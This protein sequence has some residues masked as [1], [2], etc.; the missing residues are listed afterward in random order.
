MLKLSYEGCNVFAYLKGGQ[1][2]HYHFDSIDDFLNSK[3]KG[4]VWGTIIGGRDTTVEE[5]L[6]SRPNFPL[7]QNEKDYIAWAVSQP[8]LTPQVR[9]DLK[10]YHKFRIVSVATAINLEIKTFYSP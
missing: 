7:F 4:L 5:A 6:F 2:A 8:K 1:I 9:K 3:K 10:D